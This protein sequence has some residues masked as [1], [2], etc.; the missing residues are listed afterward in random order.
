[1]FTFHWLPAL[2]ILS[3][4][5]LLEGRTDAA[6]EPS[7]T[8]PFCPLFLLLFPL[9]LSV[10]LRDLLD[11]YTPPSNIQQMQTNIKMEEKLR[12]EF[13]E[14]GAVDVQIRFSWR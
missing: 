2:Y 1:M 3:N 7:K 5:P 10:F 12:E 8:L 4:P 9:P 13:V 14:L 11:R 6:W